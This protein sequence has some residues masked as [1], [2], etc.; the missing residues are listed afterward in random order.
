M[1]VS[2]DTDPWWKPRYFLLVSTATFSASMNTTTGMIKAKLLFGDD[3]FLLHRTVHEHSILPLL[4]LL[5]LHRVLK[6]HR[7]FGMNF[8]NCMV[9]A[10]TPVDCI[11]SEFLGHGVG[12]YVAWSL[13]TERKSMSSVVA[14]REEIGRGCLL[15]GTHLTYSNDF[16]FKESNGNTSHVLF[17]F[18]SLDSWCTLVAGKNFGFLHTNGHEAPDAH[19]YSTEKPFL[20]GTV[21][22]FSEDWDWTHAEFQ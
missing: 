8:G 19:W 5:Y 16:H 14:F 6:K 22:S 11:L 17:P 10:K 2:Q 21:F 13:Q 7:V 18:V 1:S 20:L 3:E 15:H 9:K 12:F 4:P